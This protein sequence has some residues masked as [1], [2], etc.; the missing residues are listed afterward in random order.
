M[1]DFTITFKPSVEKDLRGLPKT[2]IADILERI[3]KLD[4]N[5]SA[6]PAKK[7]SGTERMYRLRVGEYRVVFEVDKAHKTVVIHYI[8]H[9]REVYRHL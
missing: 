9:R 3:S 1:G 7:L 5:P 6:P 8:R 2:V 4:A